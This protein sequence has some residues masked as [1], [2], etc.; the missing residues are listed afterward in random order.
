MQNLRDKLII[1]TCL[2][3]ITTT[4][5][6]ACSDS[7]YVIY[8]RYDNILEA[9]PSVS[10][11]KLRSMYAREVGMKPSAL[12]NLYVRC[13]MRWSSNQSPSESAEY[14][15]SELEG[16]AKDCAKHP[17]DLVCKSFLGR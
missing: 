17:N 1:G 2:L 8:Q 3:L 15:K 7:E 9:N 5:N 12:K 13:T 11:D 16:L 4:S 14:T 10:D 6:A